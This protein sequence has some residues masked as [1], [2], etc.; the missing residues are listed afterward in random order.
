MLIF[1]VKHFS[2]PSNIQWAQC[3]KLLVKKPIWIITLQ[4]QKYMWVFLHNHSVNYKPFS[5]KNINITWSGIWVICT[6]KFHFQMSLLLW[7][8]FYHIPRV[9][10]KFIREDFVWYKINWSSQSED[11]EKKMMREK[12]WFV[13]RLVSHNLSSWSKEKSPE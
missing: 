6:K 10:V 4:L 13:W 7:S 2:Q 3:H 1:K 9:P 12:I 11:T 5:F 8:D